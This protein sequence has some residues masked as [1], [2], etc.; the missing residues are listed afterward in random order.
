MSIYYFLKS[1]Q[2]NRYLYTIL[3]IFF[4]FGLNLTSSRA[5]MLSSAIGILYLFFFKSIKP[6]DI[7]LFISLYL[8]TTILST[9][10]IDYASI[11]KF[12]DE[13]E[14]NI[15]ST[16]SRFMIW[17]AT[18]L[19]WLDNPFIGIGIENFKFLNA[20]Y[21]I[22]ALNILHLP[23]TNLGNYVWAHSEFLQ[24]LAELGIIGFLII[25]I[26][27]YTFLKK[28]HKNYNNNYDMIF[29]TVIILVM[30][31]QSS[32][33]WELRHPYFMVVL[34]MLIS[35][36]DKNILFTLEGIRKNIFIF[37]SITILII[38]ST[39][40]TFKLYNSLLY[41]FT[42][43]N[44]KNIIESSLNNGYLFWISASKYLND[45][46]VDLLEKKFGSKKIPTFKE[47][48]IHLKDVK[49][50]YK[51]QLNKYLKCS[52]KLYS[53]HK[54]W[55]A[56]YYYAV[57]LMLD[58]RFKESIKICKEGIELSPNSNELFFLWHLNNIFLHSQ[59]TGIDIKEFLPSKDSEFFKNLKNMP[60]LKT[61]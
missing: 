8:I 53:I 16:E 20:P 4:V 55:I 7:F 59:K 37:I 13:G 26:N 51:D 54:I 31:I 35:Y 42:S 30:L 34:T 60:M 46:T 43:N 39:Y 10:A 18:I 48:I 40:F 36:G 44:T 19:M 61:D 49:L 29:K 15:Y 14:P 25:F 23:T 12:I 45:E 21:Q 5:G 11:H 1:N 28:V 6:K 57:G 52:Q 24:L 33:S 9:F 47:E 41:S 50:E 2:K 32:F 56:N 3:F 58:N 22:K 38:L 17:L 27:F